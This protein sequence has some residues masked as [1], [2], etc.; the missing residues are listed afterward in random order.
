MAVPIC[1]LKVDSYY[2]NLWISEFLLNANFTI[3]RYR[4]A[5]FTEANISDCRNQLAPSSG[6]T[7]YNY[8]LH[9]E[10]ASCSRKFETLKYILD[11]AEV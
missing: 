9:E 7:H 3:A 11:M 1:S 5:Q 10:G 6:N 4:R 8:V 2:L